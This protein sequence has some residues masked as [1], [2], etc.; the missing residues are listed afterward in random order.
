MKRV[1]M[2]VAL[3]VLA[4]RAIALSFGVPPIRALNFPRNDSLLKFARRPL[5]VAREK[6]SDPRFVPVPIPPRAAA[7]VRGDHFPR[8]TAPRRAGEIFRRTEPRGRDGPV[9]LDDGRR[10]LAAAP[11]PHDR[12]RG[13][14]PAVFARR[15]RVVDR[16][17]DQGEDGRRIRPRARDRPERRVRDPD[18]PDKHDRHLEPD[19]G[20]QCARGD[21]M[22][23][24]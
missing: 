12:L 18:P 6:H 16:R 13:V 1:L 19:V 9:R 17:G 23:T 8:R 7:H 21:P 2:V 3:L 22:R 11:P 10:R 14:I 5:V 24:A 20:R 15:L 4:A